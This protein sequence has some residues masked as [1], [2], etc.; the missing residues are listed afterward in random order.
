MGLHLVMMNVSIFPL[1]VG[2]FQVFVWTMTAM[3]FY[4]AIEQALVIE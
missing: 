4:I 2:D 1:C 3:G